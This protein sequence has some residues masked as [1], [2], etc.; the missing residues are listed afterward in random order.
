M[1][2]PAKVREATSQYRE[3]QDLIG[4]FIAA[5]CVLSPHAETRFTELYEAYKLWADAAREFKMPARKFAE[6]LKKREGL[7][8]KRKEGQVYYVG[9]GLRDSEG[10][11]DNDLE[12]AS[13]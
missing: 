4:Q 2:Y 12:E 8:K 7:E 9:I 10:Q 13:A 11:R 6:A 5:K 1:M 3:S